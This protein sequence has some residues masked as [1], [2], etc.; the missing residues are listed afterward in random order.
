MLARSFYSPS[1]GYNT[2]LFLGFSWHQLPSNCWLRGPLNYQCL[3]I[4][5]ANSLDLAM[6]PCC[7]AL[8]YLAQAAPI[9][10]GC[11]HIYCLCSATE[12]W[13]VL[14]YGQVMILKTIRLLWDHELYYFSFCPYCYPQSSSASTLIFCPIR[15]LFLSKLILCILMQYYSF[16]CGVW[17]WC[18]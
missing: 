13:L 7:F 11:H 3:L 2:I 6:K 15:I 16:T 12:Y 18:Q 9:L 4:T 8:Q 5:V 1:I 10:Q 14:H 17:F